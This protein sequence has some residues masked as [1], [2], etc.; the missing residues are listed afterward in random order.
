MK[1]KKKVEPEKITK[2]KKFAE[3]LGEKIQNQRCFHDF[4]KKIRDT[5]HK[6]Y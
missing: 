4:I 1:Y 3:C 2:T 5:Q 6:V